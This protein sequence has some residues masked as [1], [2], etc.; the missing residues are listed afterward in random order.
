MQGLADTLVA[1]KQASQKEEES[2]KKFLQQ[3]DAELIAVAGRIQARSRDESVSIEGDT[4]QD[5]MSEDSSMPETTNNLVNSII[6]ARELIKMLLER[7]TRPPMSIPP[8]TNI[9][10]PNIEPLDISKSLTESYR[11]SSIYN[12]ILINDDIL[13][14]LSMS[15][16]EAVVY[17]L[18][19]AGAG[20][21]EKRDVKLEDLLNITGAGAEE[22]FVLSSARLEDLSSIIEEESGVDSA[23]NPIG[24]TFTLPEIK[25]N[26]AESPRTLNK[27]AHIN[28]SPISTPKSGRSELKR[29][30]SFGYSDVP[31]PLSESNEM[32]KAQ[33]QDDLESKNSKSG[34]LEG[35]AEFERLK[36]DYSGLLEED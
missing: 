1:I 27:A 25:E 30:Q 11:D 21:E 5:S 17:S 12:K 34:N 24:L 16:R 28:L 20:I 10:P 19:N 7:N 36:R 32:N 14:S 6:K 8:L 31:T 33:I 29:S 26:D 9:N 2:E 18:I 15:E 13:N 22:K 3:I 4:I 35:T 23:K